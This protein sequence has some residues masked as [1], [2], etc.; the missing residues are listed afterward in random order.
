MRWCVRV[1]EACSVRFLPQK[2]GVIQELAA[3]SFLA[4]LVEFSGRSWSDYPNAYHSS[5]Q[6]STPTAL[7][8]SQPS[9][10]GWLLLKLVQGLV[11]QLLSHS[12]PNKLPPW[13][14]WGAWMAVLWIGA[15]G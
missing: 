5:S 13:V 8:P 15:S 10:L 11:C 9:H 7:T 2:L 12:V 4:G 6:F 3:L 1:C 14:C